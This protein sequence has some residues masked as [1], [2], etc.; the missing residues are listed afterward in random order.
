MFKENSEN[1]QELNECVNDYITFCEDMCVE[2]KE[3]V[4]Y[5][6]NKPWL[7]KELK[8]RLNEKKNIFL[9]GD[10]NSLKQKQ[11]E[12]KSLIKK[13]KHAYK[14]K[15]ERQ[16]K[17]GDSRKTWEG[18]KAAVNYNEKKKEAPGQFNIDELNSFYARF[19]CDSQNEQI[20][21]TKIRLEDGRLNDGKI[22]FDEIEIKQAFERINERRASGPDGI[23]GKLLKICSNE[24]SSIY[25]YIF[26]LS[27]C[28]N[29]IPLIWKTSKIIPIPKKDK[30]MTM[31]GL[32]P[33]ALT[34]VVM[35]TLE[36]L[37]LSKL[38]VHIR[39][40]LDPF[41]FAYQPK[42]S[43]E[44]AISVFTNNIYK[45]LE[46]QKSYCRILFIDFSSAFNTIR[47]LLLV[48]KMR[49]LEINRNIIAWVLNFLIERTQFVF[50]EGNAS[51]TITT[52]T[53]A[54]QGCVI[55]PVLF[56]L[57]TN[58]CESSHPEIPLL[59]FADDTTLQGL[60]T[61]GDESKYREEIN[62]F[63]TWCDTYNLT[64][65]VSKTKEMVIDFRRSRNSLE[66]LRIKTETV[67]QV[68]TYRYLGI[69]IDNELKWSDHSNY[70]KSKMNKRMY[71]L[72]KLREFNIDQTLCTLFYKATIESMLTFCIASWGGNCLEADRKNFERII[73]R[74]NRYTNPLKTF[75]E[76][77]EQYALRKLCAIKSDNSHPMSAQIVKSQRSDR[78]I[79]I[80]TKTE[81]HRKSFLPSSIRLFN[82]NINR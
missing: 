69:Q 65:N 31:N 14:E 40:K 28:M 24:L 27:L 59:K 34:S 11:R 72:R 9:K 63:V 17:S 4:I 66:P 1:V 39:P 74:A 48:E 19:E 78:I 5:P 35:K 18:L 3:V 62:R 10:K 61:N 29:Q 8:D 71:F 67:E 7:T 49:R 82:E 23:K 16:F 2:K 25:T 70:V 45:H 73:K 47:P 20:Q 58:D 36:K 15:I 79:S 46:R 77:Y 53:G 22:V 30:V 6:N 60:I 75:T 55:S 76:L 37:V 54:P 64:L 43:V 26:N 68:K 38:N 12:I 41:Q 80:M 51:K 44:D 13:C 56:T 81:R 42:R 52:N 21:E 32:R 50:V 57:Y 33:V